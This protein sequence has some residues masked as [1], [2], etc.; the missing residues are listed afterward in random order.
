MGRRVFRSTLDE[1]FTPSAADPRIPCSG[2]KSATSL[3]CRDA[4]SR[5]MML[6]PRAST[7]VWL[8]INPTRLPRAAG[9]TSAR[10]CSTPGATVLVSVDWAPAGAHTARASAT[11]ARIVGR[12][13]ELL[14]RLGAGG[15]VLTPW[16]GRLRR[17]RRLRL[18]FVGM[19]TTVV[20]L[21]LLARVE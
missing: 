4:K 13:R 19:L 2:P 15:A 9:G 18:R 5:S 6:V 20:L 14:D 12:K 3:I 17:K 1:I 11:S 10:N 21:E 16:S 7:P 8:V